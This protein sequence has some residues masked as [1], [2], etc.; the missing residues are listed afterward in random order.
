MG[1]FMEQVLFKLGFDDL[2]ILTDGGRE[3]IMVLQGL[4]RE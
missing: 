3:G 4:P 2:K 1:N